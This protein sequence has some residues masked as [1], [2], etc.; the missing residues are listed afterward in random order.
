MHSAFVRL[1]AVNPVS[2]VRGESYRR[3]TEMS[4]E[5]FNNF[6]TSLD[7]LEEAQAVARK[8]AEKYAAG[9][10]NNLKRAK[11]DVSDYASHVKTNAL[12]LAQEFGYPTGKLDWSC[13]Y[14]LDRSF[15]EVTVDF[16]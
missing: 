10:S 6:L 7:D 2:P 1:S 9:R 13:R 11:Q 5:M 8:E 12:A 4:R 3:Y 14:D 16:R 15:N